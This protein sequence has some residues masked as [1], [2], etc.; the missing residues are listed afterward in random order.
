MQ[1]GAQL[2]NLRDFCKTLPDLSDTLARVAAMGYK[3][4]QLSGVCDYTPEW[5]SVELR[6]TVSPPI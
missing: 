6:K 5:I 4:V 1:I 2:Y 3:T